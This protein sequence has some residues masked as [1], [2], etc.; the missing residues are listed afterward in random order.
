[1]SQLTG[2]V[3]LIIDFGLTFLVA[4][5]PT[6]AAGKFMSVKA[7]VTFPI[8]SFVGHKLY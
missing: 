1:M 5:S 4:A 3:F 2:F 6:V 8:R 7:D